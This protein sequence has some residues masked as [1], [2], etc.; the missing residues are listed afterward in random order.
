M[1]RP[2]CKIV[3][4]DLGLLDAARS[5]LK[6]LNLFEI[7][8]LYS[9]MKISCNGYW[10]DK[11]ISEVLLPAYMDHGVENGCK[12]EMSHYRHIIFCMV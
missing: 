2:G 7:E 11:V 3:S 5:C 12:E 4:W 8:M 9:E 1:L 6:D 10:V